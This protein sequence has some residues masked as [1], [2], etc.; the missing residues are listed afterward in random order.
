MEKNKNK[1]YLGDSVYA[2]W[3]NNRVCL[4]TE[5]GVP[6]DPSNIIYLEGFVIDQL[7]LFLAAIKERLEDENNA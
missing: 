2:E 4:T 6:G 1:A 3:S 7:G 5:N